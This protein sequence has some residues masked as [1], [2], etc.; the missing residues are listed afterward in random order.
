MEDGGAGVQAAMRWDN[1]VDACRQR[2]LAALED[3]V[4]AGARALAQRLGGSGGP[5]RDEGRAYFLGVLSRAI[6]LALSKYQRILPADTLLG[7][8]GLQSLHGIL[9]FQL[10]RIAFGCRCTAAAGALAPRP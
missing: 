7:K 3:R 10:N 2:L 9:S 5:H 4:R 1:E 8:R 6:Q